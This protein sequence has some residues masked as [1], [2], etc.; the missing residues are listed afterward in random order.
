M[1]LYY[2]SYNVYFF[3]L[4]RTTSKKLKKEKLQ[5]VATTLVATD[6]ISDDGALVAMNGISGDD[7]HYRQHFA[8]L[9]ATFVAT[10]DRYPCSVKS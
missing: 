9:T 4:E 6:D 8:P 10:K 2:I 3:H 5:L 1:F 7:R